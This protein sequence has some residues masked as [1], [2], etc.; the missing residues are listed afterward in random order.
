MKEIWC[1]LAFKAMEAMQTCRRFLAISSNKHFDGLA[2]NNVVEAQLHDRDSSRHGNVLLKK[3]K[4]S[5]VSTTQ[6]IRHVMAC[7]ATVGLDFACWYVSAS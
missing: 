1:A 2:A 7:E 5:I 4:G 6:V 3:K